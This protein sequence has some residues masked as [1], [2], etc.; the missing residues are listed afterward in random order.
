MAIQ[1]V[2]FSASLNQ[3]Q[4]L[5]EKLGNASSRKGS[6]AKAAEGISDLLGKAITELDA[7]QKSA[8][9]SAMKLLAGEPVDLHQVMLQM[10]ESFVN[11]NLALQVRNKIIEAYQEIQR[12]QI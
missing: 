10:E 6:P 12:M 4:K 9:E 2:G 7:S 8:D 11:L 3:V 5:S 1:S